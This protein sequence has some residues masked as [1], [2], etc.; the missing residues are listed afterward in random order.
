M[1][2]IGLKITDF[3]KTIPR[4]HKYNYVYNSVKKLMETE[5]NISLI[6]VRRGNL[7]RTIESLSA[8]QNNV[9]GTKLLFSKFLL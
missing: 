2:Y 4:K 8:A 7:K 5:N 6:W 9:I 3:L 1:Q